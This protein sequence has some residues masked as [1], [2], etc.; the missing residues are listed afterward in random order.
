M[1]QMGERHEDSHKRQN[2]ELVNQEAEIHSK[3]LYEITG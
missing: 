1:R 2:C 3:R